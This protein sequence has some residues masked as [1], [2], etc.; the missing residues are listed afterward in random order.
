ME[1]GLVE[2]AEKIDSWSA[3]E[4]IMQAVK[5]RYSGEGFYAIGNSTA[6]LLFNATGCVMHGDKF[7]DIERWDSLGDTGEVVYVSEGKVQLFQAQEAY[8]EEAKHLAE[9]YNNGYVWPDT[10]I[11]NG[12]HGDEIMKQGVIFA[13]IQNSEIGVETTKGGSIGFELVC[14]IVYSGTIT[15]GSVKTWGIGIPVT[16]DEPEA[17]AYF[18]NTLYTDAKVMNLLMW[19]IEGVDYD[20]VDGQVKH[21]E[22]GHYYE[23]DFLIGDNTLLT[24]LY[25]NG[26]DFYDKVKA[27]I[28]AAPVSPYLGFVLDASN[29]DLAISQLLVVRDQYRDAMMGGLYTPE[30]YQEYVAKLEAA[31]VED[32]LAEI[33][34]Q[35]DA[36][37]AAR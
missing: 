37:L 23:S 27:N 7:A 36:W 17:A 21:I 10:P 13:T 11:S 25:G 33:Q 2:Q 31:G 18:I 15:T 8:E 12:A 30:L 16:A 3:F 34:R 6:S 9:W 4:E 32:Y 29:L 22:D 19:G 14:P 28:A 24:P 1:L 5:D 26:S 20:V 35:L